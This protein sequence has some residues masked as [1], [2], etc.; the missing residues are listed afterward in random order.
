[1]MLLKMLKATTLALR[2]VLGRIE[3]PYIVTAR[4]IATSIV[5]DSAYRGLDE[6]QRAALADAGTAIMGAVAHT[7]GLK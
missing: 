1:M 6:A 4:E 5:T 3:V 7:K 2:I